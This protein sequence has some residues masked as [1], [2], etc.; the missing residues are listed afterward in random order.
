MADTSMISMHAEV[1]VYRQ[2]FT[3]VF[4]SA[5]SCTPQETPDDRRTW[6]RQLFCI[7]TG[8]LANVFSTAHEQALHRLIQAAQSSQSKRSDGCPS[9]SDKPLFDAC[10]YTRVARLLATYT[11][12]LEARVKIQ[13]ALLG[14]EIHEETPD[15]RRTWSRQLF[16][17]VTGLLANVFSTAHEQALHRLIQAAQS[18]QSKRSDGCPSSSDKPLFDACVYTRV[19]RLLATYT[20]PLEARV[21][22]QSALLGLEIH[23]LFTDARTAVGELEKAVRSYPGLADVEQ[24]ISSNSA[25]TLQP[26]QNFHT[27]L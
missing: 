3:L 27:P 16:C 2:L 13:S 19:A 10:V 5:L 17:I 15:D 8:L 9:S 6:S 4:F 7:V 14:L 22:I 23:E 21:K 18:S 26:P 20:F 25:I 24:S 11:F 1:N 12:P